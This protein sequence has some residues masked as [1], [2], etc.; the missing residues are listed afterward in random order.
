MHPD[1]VV[2]ADV[3]DASCVRVLILEGHPLVCAGLRSLIDALEGF[4]VVGE[5]RHL[6]QGL[7]LVE[8]L[9]PDLVVVDVE[10]LDD[11][12]GPHVGEV[13]DRICRRAR[14]LLVGGR[15][16]GEHAAWCLTHGASGFVVR[17]AESTEVAE[18]V[19][20]V[21]CGATYVSP[22]L[23]V[24]VLLHA[25]AQAQTRTAGLDIPLT[26]RQREVLGLVAD[27]LCSKQ[28]AQRLGISHKTVE[29]HRSQIM[30]RLGLHDVAS[31]VRYAV[32]TGLVADRD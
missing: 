7:E 25:H 2:S 21:A 9:R 8:R 1:Q 14:V 11:P 26:A 6:R 13:A 31:L 29:A 16:D 10:A 20:A 32:R 27:G 3:E 5:E 22:T 18:A 17:D 19:R 24:E 12:R 30:E 4:R 15:G 23:G 28:I